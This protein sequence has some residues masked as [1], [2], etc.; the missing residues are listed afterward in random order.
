MIFKK[1]QAKALLEGLARAIEKS[2]P[3]DEVAGLMNGDTH[4]I[5]FHGVTD[6]IQK[7]GSRKD[8]TQ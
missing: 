1:S 2:K 6:L 4:S 5:D 8:L 3:G 7:N